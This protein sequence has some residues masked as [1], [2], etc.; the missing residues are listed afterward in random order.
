MSDVTLPDAVEA[1]SQKFK[2]PGVVIGVLADS[3]EI[4]ACEGVTSLDN[5][6]PIDTDTLYVLGSLTK[7]YTATTLMCLVAE[8]KVEVDAP[9]RR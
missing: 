3:K 2:I 9:V 7:T 6:L 5:P 1:L 8:G 4:Y